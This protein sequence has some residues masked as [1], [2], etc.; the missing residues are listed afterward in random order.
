MHDLLAFAC[1][2]IYL[3]MSQ[4]YIYQSFLFFYCVF[5][6]ALDILILSNN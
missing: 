1:L 5:Q 4:E 2:A 3:E 6:L